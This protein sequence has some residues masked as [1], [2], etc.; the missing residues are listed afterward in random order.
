MTHF[1]QTPSQLLQ[2][3]HPKRISREEYIPPLCFDR[4]KIPSI[5]VFTPSVARV[6]GKGYGAVIAMACSV[7]KLLI[8]HESFMVSYYKWT[9]F[10]DA[11]NVPFTIKYEKNKLLIPNAYSMAEKL[12]KDLHT[13][14]PN[15]VLQPRQG[16]FDDAES[17]SPSMT[18]EKRSSNPSTAST[19]NS[20]NP[21]GVGGNNN[22]GAWNW[23][24]FGGFRGTARTFI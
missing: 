16:S 23:R 11:D 1:G 22:A 10:P 5:K 21:N 15:T 20:P 6:N 19:N 4:M 9:A 8:V 24:S 12:M 7:D 18:P 14:Q 17:N 3:P 2:K 13:I